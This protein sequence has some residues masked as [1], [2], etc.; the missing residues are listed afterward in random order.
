MRLALLLLLALAVSAEAQGRFS[1]TN[2]RCAQGRSSRGFGC[3]DYAF[4]EFAPSTG[5][6]L[7]TVCACT[8]VTGAK[9][10]AVTVTRASNATCSPLGVAT[11]GITNASLVECG[12]NTP[13][14]EVLSSGPRA[15]RSE[16][17]HTN[18]LV[19]FTDFADA[20]WADVATPTLT[21]SQTSVW[22][23]T[24]ANQAVRFD[25]NDAL[26]FEGRTQT[27][28]V[29]ATAAYTMCCYV[30][31]GTLAKAR[32]SLD[33][34]TADYAALS[35]TTWTLASVTD[36]SASGVAIAAQALNGTVVGDT[37]TVIWG[38][39]HVEAGLFCRSMVPTVASTASA[40][41]DAISGTPTSDLSNT[42]ICVAAT[43]EPL[44]SGS[45]FS[46]ST[47]AVEPIWG[48]TFTLLQATSGAFNSTLLSSANAVRAAQAGLVRLIGRDDGTNVSITVGGGTT[49]VASGVA[50]D[51]FGAAYGIASG[52]SGNPLDGLIAL[53][54]VDPSSSRCQ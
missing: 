37:G 46:T 2:S 27:V 38:G 29:T 11:T 40:N 1:R 35:T 8:A 49:T 10:E 9:G 41:A 34:T 21:G 14:V 30:K 3:E 24:F 4:A 13:R 50:A 42:T 17:A 47:V 15:L 48:G 6:G 36:A 23:G 19:R 44:W 51:R 33:G 18:R 54:Q 20:A 32:L 25:D 52:A 16:A 5:A 26:A 45:N 53:V 28:T 31:G 7:S 22:S 39:C 43:I 12:A